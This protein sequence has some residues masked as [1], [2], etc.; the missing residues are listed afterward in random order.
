[1][2]NEVRLMG[3]FGADPQLDSLSNGS[4][5]SRFPLSLYRRGSKS[6]NFIQ[7]EAWAGTS[8]LITKYG[9]KG[10][11]AII[12]GELRVDLWKNEAGET[13]S[14]TYVNVNRIIFPDVRI[15][16]NGGNNGGQSNT[17]NDYQNNQQNNRQNNTNNSKPA[18]NSYSKPSSSNTNPAD[19]VDLDNIFDGID[20]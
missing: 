14:K 9:K 5:K 18:N 8:E 10:T 15:E 6:G 13:R 1:M 2:I 4:K 3:Y 17:Y 12:E 11:R 19:D 16:N 20:F 7:C